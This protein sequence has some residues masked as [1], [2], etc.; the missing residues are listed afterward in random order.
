MIKNPFMRVKYENNSESLD[1]TKDNQ[2]VDINKKE[3]CEENPNKNISSRSIDI[4]HIKEYLIKNCIEDIKKEN[5]EAIYTHVLEFFNMKNVFINK[6]ELENV[7]NVL[8]NEM[9]GYGILEKYIN[10]TDITDIRVIS[11]SEIYVKRM[12]KW[13]LVKDSFLSKEQYEE[14]IRYV[15]TRNSS[16]VNYETPII[17]ISDKKY[18]LR[19]EIG[20]EPV[21]I[22][23]PSM[24]IRIHRI[25]QNTTLEKLFLVDEM[26]DETS[27]EMVQNI[28]SNMSSCIISGRRR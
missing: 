1:V 4:K 9:Y 23:S 3:Q 10:D 13:I 18:K 16:V 24:V 20:I 22:Y 5:K 12:G 15:V 11:Y 6:E 28:I 27:Y 14:Y 7:I 19:I 17:T 21:N 2:K 26:L 8:L 25:D